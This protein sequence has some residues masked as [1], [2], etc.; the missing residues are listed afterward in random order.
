MAL[1]RIALATNGVAMFM[2]SF[3]LFFKHYALWAKGEGRKAADCKTKFDVMIWR[4]VGLWVAFVGLA[5][6]FVTDVPS[7]FWSTRWGF[8]PG[9]LHVIWSP[10]AC[11]VAITH[12]IETWVKYEALGTVSRC[13]RGASG[14]IFL[15]GFCLLAVIL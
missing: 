11:L 9:D 4:I 7:G 2:W 12:A 13:L 1:L 3:I 14:N 6:L 15:G 5:C 10:L 8:S